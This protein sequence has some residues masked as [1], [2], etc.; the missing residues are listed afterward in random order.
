LVIDADPDAN[1]GDLIGKELHFSETLGGRMREFRKKLQRNE[2]PPLM[3]KKQV[4]EGEVFSALIEKEEFDF[5]EMG[6]TEGEG[7]YCFIN[8]VLKHAIDVISENYEYTLVDTPA[9]LEHFARK[10]GR[11]VSDLIVVVDPSYMAI[12]TLSRIIEITEEVALTFEKIWIVGNRYSETTKEI[13]IDKIE[14]IKRKLVNGKVIEF[15]GFLPED[16]EIQRFNLTRKSI[17]KLS[18]E[19]PAYNAAKEFFRKL[20]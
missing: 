20:L 3:N 4:I 11:D 15:L 9:G 16:E 6:R 12:H 17:L 13:L 1:I 18:P 2:L 8:D 14:S 10:T 5:M 19:N 7:C